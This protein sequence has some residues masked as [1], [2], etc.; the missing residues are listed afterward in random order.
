[1]LP[2][3]GEGKVKNRKKDRKKERKKGGPG[4]KPLSPPTSI[5][6]LTGWGET[7]DWQHTQG[8][9]SVHLSATWVV[10]ATP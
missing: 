1:M 2:A 3:T 5:A 9:L 7:V 6:G 8:F 10:C 4:K